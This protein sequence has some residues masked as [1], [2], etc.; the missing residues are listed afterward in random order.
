MGDPVLYKKKFLYLLESRYKE[1]S[2]PIALEDLALSFDDVPQPDVFPNVKHELCPGGAQMQVTEEN[3]KHYLWLL[4]DHRLRA[5]ISSHLDALRKGFNEVV[6]SD[7]RRRIQRIVSPTEFGF[8]LCGIEELDAAD[9][10]THSVRHEGL[11]VEVWDRFWNVVKAMSQQQRAQLLEFV[12]GSPTLPAGGFQS[13]PGY[14]GP[15]AVEPFTVAPPVR[16]GAIG[17]NGL[18]LPTA[19]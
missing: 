16:A 11:A 10:Q 5:S 6:P 13:L 2:S 15:S 12:T 17:G 18:G 9:W 7:V 19:A 1:G 8:L 4:C 14:G 3:K